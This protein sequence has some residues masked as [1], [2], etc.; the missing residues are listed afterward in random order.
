MRAEG[1]YSGDTRVTS[2]TPHAALLEAAAEDLAVVNLLALQRPAKDDRPPALPNLLAF[3]GTAPALQLPGHLVVVNTLN[4]HPVLGTV[5][6]L[7]SHRPVYPLRFG[8]P[9]GFDDWSVMDWCEQC[10][11]KRGLVVWPDLPRLSAEHPQGEALAALLLGQIDAFEVSRFRDPEPAVLGDWYRLLDS[12]LRVPLVGGSGKDSNAAPLGRVRTYARLQPGEEFS[13]ATW[14]EAIRAGRT[15]AGNG[16]LLF[17]TVDGQDPGAVIAPHEGRKAMKIHIEARSQ[18]PFDQ[19]ELLVNGRIQ[20][21]KTASGNRL[22]ALL[23]VEL[24]FEHSA[25]IAARC[26][27]RES[28]AGDAEHCVYAHTSPVYVQVQGKP[29]RPDRE[30]LAPLDKV[31]EQTEA[32]VRNEARC[33]MDKQRLQLLGVFEAAPGP[34][35]SRGLSQGGS[36]PRENPPPALDDP[37]PHRVGGGRHLWL[38]RGGK[39]QVHAVRL[40]ST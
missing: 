25:W 40:R 14:I 2:L 3:S 29:I 27:G 33:P 18:V 28:M 26:W 16:P 13:Y 24:P 21:S 12:G 20:A 15:F 11:R 19:V 36:A 10:H 31:L 39:R 1:W 35:A 5:A 30:T 34:A 4:S 23:D 17:L 22:A 6:L 38:L 8:G 37:D 32:W 7:N 9:D